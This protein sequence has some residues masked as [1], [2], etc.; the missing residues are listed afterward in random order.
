MAERGRGEVREVPVKHTRPRASNASRPQVWATSSTMWVDSSTVRVR[1]DVRQQGAEVDA[2]LRVEADGGLVDD[3]QLG[4][5]EQRLG[6]A[7]APFHAAGQPLELASGD[8]GEADFVE[9]RR[10]LAAAV[11]TV[12][13]ALEDGDV[14]EELRGGQVG[15]EASSCGR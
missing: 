1:T 3:E 8:V 14:V 4:V 12:V 13:A 15:V 11:G 9:Q 7:D 2:F 5:A 6:D 10:D